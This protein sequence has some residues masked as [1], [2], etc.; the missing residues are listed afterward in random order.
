MHIVHLSV[1]FSLYILN[2]FY[3]LKLYMFIYLF[4]FE[5]KSCFVAQAG[6]ELTIL[7]P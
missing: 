1:F 5:M 7:L 4:V 3:F 6:L 2:I